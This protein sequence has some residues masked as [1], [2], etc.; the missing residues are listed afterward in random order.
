MKGKDKNEGNWNCEIVE[1]LFKGK[2]DAIHDLKL[3]GTKS[4]ALQFSIC[5]HSK[6]TAIRKINTFIEEH[7]PEETKCK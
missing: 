5:I 7:K 3:P 1:E 4:H 2:D 6:Y